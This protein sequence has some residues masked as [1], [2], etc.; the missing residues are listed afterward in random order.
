MQHV[1]A[2][3]AVCHHIRSQQSQLF[4]GVGQS[5]TMGIAVKKRLSQFLFQILNMFGKHGL[6]N[7][8]VRGGLAVV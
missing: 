6:R 5:Y 2:M 1:E 3:V 8:E 4:P 7:V